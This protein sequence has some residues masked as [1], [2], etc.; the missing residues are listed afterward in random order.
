MASRPPRRFLVGQL[1]K[2]VRAPPQPRVRGVIRADLV[3]YDHR[4][5]EHHL[6]DVRG[7]VQHPGPFASAHPKVMHADECLPHDVLVHLPFGPLDQGVGVL[8]DVHPLRSQARTV[9]E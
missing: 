5:H 2:L 6:R 3:V 1:S 9:R 7:P 8:H 4:V